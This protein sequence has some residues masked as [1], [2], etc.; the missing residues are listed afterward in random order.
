[1]GFLGLIGVMLIVL[2]G[3]H[4]SVIHCTGSTDNPVAVH[5]LS[6]FTVV[7]ELVSALLTTIRAVQALRTSSWKWQKGSLM[8]F[9]F[10]QG[11]LYFIFVSVF[12]TTSMVL[13]FAATPGTF[14]QTSMSTFTIPLSGLMTARFLLHLR[15]WESTR[16][17]GRVPTA[18]N[19][20]D[21]M[22]FNPDARN[23]TGEGIN[24]R[25]SM[26]EYGDDP[27]QRSRDGW[28]MEIHNNEY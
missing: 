20:M 25:W 15:E 4:I 22:E 7:F 19:P 9:I 21:E 8:Y 12:A 3:L 14:L 5:L 13:D 24:A 26:H 28:V 11:I 18:T 16:A 10:E 23:T 17:I 2:A 6:I 27:V 1:M